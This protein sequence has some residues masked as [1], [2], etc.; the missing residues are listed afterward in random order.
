MAARPAVIAWYLGRIYLAVAA[1][2]AVPAAASVAV[3]AAPRL[4]GA[5]AAPV[6]LL[7]LAGV[8]LQRGRRVQDVQANEAMALTALVFVT[9]PL[10]LAPVFA[11]IGLAP[12]DAL[13]ES[14]AAVTTAGL[15]MVGSVAELPPAFLFTRAWVQWFGGL[16]IV[17]LSLALVGGPGVAA[18]RISAEFDRDLSYASS[19]HARARLVVVVYGALTAVGL[20]ALWLATGDFFL[21]V[22]HALAAVATGGY[23]TFDGG[24]SG[25]EALAPQIVIL[26]LCVAG[27]LSFDLHGRLRRRALDTYLRDPGLAA[28]LAAVVA[29]T[30]A[31]FLLEAGAGGAGLWRAL[32]LAVMAQTT[33]G[34]STVPLAELEA[35]TQVV[36]A[37]SMLAGGDLGSTAGGVKLLRLLI[38]ARLLQL[39]LYRLTLPRHAVLVARVEGRRVA[40]PEIV[41]IAAFLTLLAGVIGLSWL[42]FVASGEAPFASLVEVIAAVSTAGLSP[43]LAGPELAPHLKLVLVADMLAGRLEVVA[44]VVLL[45]PRTWIGRRQRS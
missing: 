37:A 22:T 14:Y 42:A 9:V 1:L 6:V 11:A 12:L 43:G 26:V 5:C 33:A 44:L 31:V 10:A 17:A 23:S 13:F 36:L 28:L 45:Y 18:R 27:A 15:T 38:L 25:F 32:N 16:G 40:E 20:A 2:M 35:S 19:T 34:F 3:F 21:A 39:L 41:A 24:P 7:G 29:V 8:V 4:A 30:A